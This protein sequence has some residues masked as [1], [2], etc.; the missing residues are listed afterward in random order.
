MTLTTQQKI[1]ITFKVKETGEEI[2]IKNVK[3]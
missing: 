1:D 3:P 2:N